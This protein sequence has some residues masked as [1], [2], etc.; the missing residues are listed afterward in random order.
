[1]S[2]AQWIFLSELDQARHL[3]LDAYKQMYGVD[4]P[5]IDSRCWD[6][7]DWL[8]TKTDELILQWVMADSLEAPRSLN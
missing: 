8:A 4:S 7:I 6:D 1:M 2:M 5:V 3:Y